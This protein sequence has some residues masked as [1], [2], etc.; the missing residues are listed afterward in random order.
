[1]TVLANIITGN[2]VAGFASGYDAVMTTETSGSN[3]RV[4][5][6]CRR[7]TRGAV[8]IFAYVTACDVVGRFVNS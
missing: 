7:P 1:M 3:T 2:V 5:E 6:I 4:V 8:A